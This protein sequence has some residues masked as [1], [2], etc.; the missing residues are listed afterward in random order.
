MKDWKKIKI[1]THKSITE[2]FIMG[3]GSDLELGSVGQ[4]EEIIGIILESGMHIFHDYDQNSTMNTSLHSLEHID[5]KK[6][7]IETDSILHRTISIIEML[8]ARQICMKEN[9]MILRSAP[10]IMSIKF[11]RK[12][13]SE[14]VVSS[15]M[16]KIMQNAVESMTKFPLH[17]SSVANLSLLASICTLDNRYQNLIDEAM[18]LYWQSIYEQRRK[19]NI[20]LVINDLEN[21]AYAL[22]ADNSTEI[23]RKRAI[24]K[25]FYTVVKKMAPLSAT[26]FSL[27][28]KGL[29]DTGDYKAE[30]CNVSHSYSLVVHALTIFYL[31]S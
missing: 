5:I 15:I 10:F 25:L 14:A 13:C 21:L 11:V 8:L 22:V 29:I 2:K 3:V 28:I 19:A 17:Q 27:I 24:K 16:E 18:Y 9:N 26:T 1:C 31:Y 12:H 20:N 23:S 4:H 6:K 30:V 7:I